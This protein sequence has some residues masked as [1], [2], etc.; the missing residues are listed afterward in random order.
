MRASRSARENA[1]TALFEDRSAGFERVVRSILG[2]G[3]DAAAVVQDAFVKALTAVR[4]GRAPDEL[5]GWAFVL[6]MNLAKDHRRSERRRPR[7]AS[8]HE[9]GGEMGITTQGDRPTDRLSRDEAIAAARRAIHELGDAERDVFLLRV[10]GDLTF[11]EAARALDIPIGTAKTRMRSA[12]QR[13]RGQLAAFAPET[14][15]ARSPGG[16]R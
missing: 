7:V 6:T 5:E 2:P 13:L 16:A 4:D 14:H 9:L 11:E 1:L 10:T 3:G 15:G 8:L 12:L